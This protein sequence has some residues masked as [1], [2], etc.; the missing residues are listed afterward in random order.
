MKKKKTTLA[1][2]VYTNENHMHMTLFDGRAFCLSETLT[3]LKTLSPVAVIQ[4][5]MTESE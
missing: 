2:K 5:Q 1:K 3:A 4:L